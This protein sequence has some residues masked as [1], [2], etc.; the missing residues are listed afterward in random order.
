MKLRIITSVLPA[1]LALLITGLFVGCATT[2]EVQAPEGADYGPYPTNYVEIVEKWQLAQNDP[3]RGFDKL[4]IGTTSPTKAYF[5][6]A[7]AGWK[8]V[9]CMRFGP[10]AGKAI[11]EQDTVLLRNGQVFFEPENDFY[12]SVTNGPN[13]PTWTFGDPIISMQEMNA[14][15]E[16]GHD[17][18]TLT[19]P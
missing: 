19:K 12:M 13:G 5:K 15:I 1:L 9:A 10:T 7:G 18:D 3:S 8:V 17:I 16:A 6:E 14:A 2:G 4:R 11:L